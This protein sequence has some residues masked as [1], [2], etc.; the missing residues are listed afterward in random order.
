MEILSLAPVRALT[1][2]ILI[3]I[4]GAGSSCT[5]QQP[6]P[7]LSEA[8]L[9]QLGSIQVYS[10]SM[11]LQP[12]GDAPS[13]VTV[14]TAS[15]IQ[16][17]GYRTLADILRTVRSFYVT[18]DRNYSSIGVRGFARPGDYNTR[19]L[20]LV[21]GHRMNDDVY[22]EAMIGTEFPIDID[23][24]E[25]VE[26]IRGPVSSLYGSNAL[27]AVINVVT[28]HG[29]D[30]SNLE[31]S[32]E[33]GSFNTYKGR[34]SYGRVIR[35]LQLMVSGSFYGSRGQNQ[36]FFP[37]FD[38]P[39]TNNGIASHAD[40]DQ[41]GTALATVSFHDFTIQAA[42]GTREKGIPTGAYGTIF[43][44]PGTRTTDSHSYID[45]RYDRIFTGN[46]ELLA[47]LFYDRYTYQ[48]SY[49]YTSVLDPTQVTS[50]MDFADGKWWGTQIQAAK[51]VF[52]RNRITAG[53][54][55]RDN[56]RQKQSDYD[57]NP[58]TL[59]F[60]DNPSSLVGGIYLQDEVPIT[61]SLALN[62]GIRYDYYSDV[63]AST[64]PRVA[65]VYRPASKTNLKFIFGRAFRIP[66]VYERY[67]SVAPNLPNPTLRPEKLGSSEFVWEQGLADHF[68]FSTAAFHITAGDLINQQSVPG[69]LLIYRNL[70]N[71][72]SNGVELELK[73]R[74]SN[75]L[76]GVTS[77]SFQEAKD[78]DTRQFLNG[79]PRHLG[80][81][82]LIQPLLRRKLFASLDAQ[83]RSGMTTFA[84]GSVSSFPIV[85]FDLFGQ[86]IGRHLD[87]SVSFYNLLDKK[88]SDPPSTGVPESSIQQDGR[89]F[90]VKMTWYLGER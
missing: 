83:Y 1:R 90:R 8:S 23:M 82:D 52:K 11:H 49:M 62:A 85:D 10:A 80:K 58:Y 20:L 4:I 75:G 89:T 18:Y 14:I 13:S 3:F 51:T 87:L 56:F 78:S 24:I 44:N 38:S 31:F 6:A 54:E 74:L 42:F 77:Y 2:A 66:N 55:Y 48:G 26:I 88:Y 37:E 65:L 61:K 27:F 34:I 67:Y 43:N 84:G 28:R 53:F 30:L 35:Q 69:D 71:V 17:H 15:E 41:L 39:E 81:V 5:A 32:A 57:L 50:N 59:Y 64:D 73:G 86:K 60:N 36:L 76:E 72:E 40:D 12:S 79:S 68:W 22:D 7:D 45:A 47:R 63:A 19:I 9:E 21:D 25:R 29:Q 33:A 70:Q 46:W 16:E